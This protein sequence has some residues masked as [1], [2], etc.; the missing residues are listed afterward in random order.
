MQAGD[1]VLGRRFNRDTWDEFIFLYYRADKYPVV[2]LVRNWY[3]YCTVG[4]C[5]Q[6]VKPLPVYEERV[7]DSISMM[8]WLVDHEWT[9]SPSGNWY[10]DGE[11][12]SF[13]PGM[14][15]HCGKKV[16]SY[17]KYLPQ[18]IEKVEI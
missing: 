9:V 11:C 18:W 10:K 16:P 14:W 15:V 7:L 6:A 13:T 12:L 17:Y 3:N 1:K 4:F 8:K 5:I 2:Q